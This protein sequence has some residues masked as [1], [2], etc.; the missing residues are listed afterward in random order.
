[1]ASLSLTTTPTGVL[2]PVC[3]L[4]VFLSCVVCVY[5]WHSVRERRLD[6][7][8]E[9]KRRSR[10][11]SDFDTGCVLRTLKPVDKKVRMYPWKSTRIRDLPDINNNDGFEIPY[12]LAESSKGRR[13]PVM[14]HFSEPYERPELKRNPIHILGSY[15][16]TLTLSSSWS[17]DTPTS[18]C[19]VASM[20][21]DCYV[22]GIREEVIHLTHFD[23]DGQVV[24]QTVNGSL[25]EYWV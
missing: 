5:H 12:S 10:I 15:Q 2:L 14:S 18:S 16:V 4:A 22:T 17:A 25:L 21:D 7:E 8:D 9:R 24:V 11:V 6:L 19:F 13:R 3:I 23:L 20:D 1:M